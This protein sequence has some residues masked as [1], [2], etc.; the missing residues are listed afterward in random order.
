[1]VKDDPKYSRC[2]RDDHSPDSSGLQIVSGDVVTACSVC[3]A[4]LTVYHP[5][6]D[7]CWEES[8]CCAVCEEAAPHCTC[9]TFS[10][11]VSS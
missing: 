9:E 5:A 6:W 11:R 4:Q 3:G 2:R 8:D 7:A 1:M 10:P